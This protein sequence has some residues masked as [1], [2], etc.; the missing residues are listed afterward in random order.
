MEVDW[1]Y[2]KKKKEN[3]VSRATLKSL[4]SETRYITEKKIQKFKDQPT[5]NCA[6]RSHVSHFLCA[7]RNK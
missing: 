2:T 5:E 4:S 1:C 3:D 7:I 6:R